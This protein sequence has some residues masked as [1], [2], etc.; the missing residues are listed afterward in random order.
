MV[1]GEGLPVFPTPRAGALRLRPPG[2]DS[3]PATARKDF[4]RLCRE[5]GRK[6]PGGFSAPH[7]ANARGPAEQ[8]E[9]PRGRE[10]GGLFFLLLSWFG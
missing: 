5:L 1:G 10:K 4:A 3:T 2:I 7:G 8:R 9:T 6:V